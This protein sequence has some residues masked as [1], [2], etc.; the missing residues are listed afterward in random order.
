[1]KILCYFDIQRLG[2]LGRFSKGDEEVVFSCVG[3][4]LGKY[5]VKLVI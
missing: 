1:M 3:G 2:K 5:G 4:K